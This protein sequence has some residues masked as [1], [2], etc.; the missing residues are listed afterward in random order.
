MRAELSSGRRVSTL[1][2]EDGV[3]R[4]SQALRIFRSVLPAGGERQSPPPGGA[5][6]G[7]R[8]IWVLAE[9][10]QI[11]GRGRKPT[12]EQIGRRRLCCL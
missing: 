5:A 4:E 6:V 9:T 11:L 10:V 2:V 3:G 12:T 8:G 7:L 1:Q